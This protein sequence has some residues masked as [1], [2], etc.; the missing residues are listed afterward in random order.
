MPRVST[1]PEFR[2]AV[3]GF[4]VEDLPIDVEPA[5]LQAAR[6]SLASCGLND[7]GILCLDLS[8]PGTVVTGNRNSKNRGPDD[9]SGTLFDTEDQDESRSP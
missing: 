2:D 4:K 7:D 6:S 5:A 9:D 3:E 1:L 8:K